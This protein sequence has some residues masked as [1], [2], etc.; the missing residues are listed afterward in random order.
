VLCAAA[1]QDGAEK[2]EKR[3]E[4]ARHG[5]AGAE[6]GVGAGAAAPGKSGERARG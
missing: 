6:P 5:V 4:R 2:R 1:E 3:E